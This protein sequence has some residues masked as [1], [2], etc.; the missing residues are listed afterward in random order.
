M[1]EVRRGNSS[2]EFEIFHHGPKLAK[3][4]FQQISHL[5][6][7]RSA[8]FCTEFHKSLLDGCILNGDRDSL[9][10]SCNDVSGHFCRC[11][12]TI[13]AFRLNP[14]EAQFIDCRRVR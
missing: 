11:K 9:L 3:L 12:Q 7:G 10:N 5:L 14:F 13:P 2:V 1:L 8:P 4:L 6:G